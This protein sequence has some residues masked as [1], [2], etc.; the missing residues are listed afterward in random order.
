MRPDS[1]TAWTQDRSELG[2]CAQLRK[3]VGIKMS[4]DLWRSSSSSRGTLPV[5]NLLVSSLKRPEEMQS[6][7]G[8]ITV[9]RH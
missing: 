3:Q 2:F 4:W 5:F 7:E 1:G 8:L 9:Q 6:A